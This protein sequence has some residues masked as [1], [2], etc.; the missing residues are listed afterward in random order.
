MQS[1]WRMVGSAQYSRVTVSRAAV[2]S[3]DGLARWTG[4]HI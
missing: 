2:Y 1:P 3:T 4:R